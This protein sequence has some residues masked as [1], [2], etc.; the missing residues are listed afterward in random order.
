L[1]PRLPLWQLL[2]AVVGAILVIV[3]VF[4]PYAQLD[5]GTGVTLKIVRF[6]H[7]KESFW[8]GLQPIVS[9]LGPSWPRP[10]FMRVQPRLLVD[11]C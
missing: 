7:F 5:P 8:S 2:L 10:S 1:F 4:I 6:D 11:Y 3:A 9:P